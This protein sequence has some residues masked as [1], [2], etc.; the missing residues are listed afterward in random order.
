M[1]MM[2]RSVVFVVLL[3]VG[4]GMMQA[5]AQ[6]KKK[7]P[8]P[9]APQEDGVAMLDSNGDEITRDVRDTSTA[10]RY[11]LFPE[12][13]S[14]WPVVKDD[15]IIKY[16]CYDAENSYINVDTL[17]DIGDVQHIHFVKTFTNYL[18]TYIDA[19]GRPK[20][21]TASKTIYRYD[22]TG[23]DTWKSYDYSNS[24]LS[25]LQEFRSEIVRQDTTNTVNSITGAR[26][27]TIRKYYK[28]VELQKKG[29]TEI[30]KEDK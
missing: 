27:L 7:K 25:E 11:F 2:R 26:R 3:L 20:A 28:V 5:M 29:E 19:D 13:Y 4:F 6:G 14:Y 22:K 1:N 12:F 16:Q 23:N 18:H 17:H 9:A 15:T 21:S 30:Q 8:A 24:Y 10:T